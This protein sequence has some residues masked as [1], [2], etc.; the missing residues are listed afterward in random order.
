MAIP[1]SPDSRPID[2]E[3]PGD[4]DTPD[5]PVAALPDIPTDT[6]ID[7]PMSELEA[8]EARESVSDV[9]QA[10]ASGARITREYQ[11]AQTDTSTDADILR[12][13]AISD[14][15]ARDDLQ[16]KQDTDADR[17]VAEGE[18]TSSDIKQGA[19]IRV[20]GEF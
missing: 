3:T 20:P 17:L 10:I 16:D 19:Q 11:T 12:E 8:I 9:E 15:H 18:D 1:Q 5:T 13:Q 14:S 6:V 4:V 7:F 2:L